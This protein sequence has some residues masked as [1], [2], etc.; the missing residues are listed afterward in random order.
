[1]TPRRREDG[2]GLPADA[3]PFL[4]CETAFVTATA[5]HHT[6][7]DTGLVDVRRPRLLHVVQGHA[8]RSVAVN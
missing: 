3:V 6:E 2:F 5:T 7:Y 1:M 8:S 4:G